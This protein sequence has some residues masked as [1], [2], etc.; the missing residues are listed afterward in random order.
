MNCC[1]KLS[2][3]ASILLF[4]ASSCSK[5]FERVQ[6]D[7]PPLASSEPSVET[8]PKIAADQIPFF[9]QQTRVGAVHTTAPLD[10]KIITKALKFPWSLAFLPDGRMLVTEKP[11]NMRI[12]TSSGTVGAPITGLPPVKYRSNSGL[13]DVV[14]DP[15]FASTRSIFWV[16]VEPLTP[17]NFITSIAKGKLSVDETKLE[18]LKIIYRAY[19]S[20]T[21]LRHNG[22]QLLFDKSGYLYACFGEHY[23][24]VVRVLAQDLSSSI[25][26]II[27][28]QKDG[29]AAPGN[30]F[31]KTPGALPEIWSLGHRDPQGL[32]FNPLTGDLWESEHGPM[33]GDEINLI[34]AGYNYGWPVI[35]YGYENSGP[36]MGTTVGNGTHQQGMKQP[37]YYWDPA[38]AP[39]GIAFY[40]GALI[41]EWK[42]N[43]FVAS[44]LGKHI[45]RLVLYNNQVFGE[46][47][48]LSGEGQRFRKVIQGPDGAIYAITDETEGRI[49]RI[50]V[51]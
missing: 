39:S 14:L 45:S 35:A 17:T 9:Q 7:P 47:R 46:E 50:G 1:F 12:V 16:F 25:G 37:V 5:K 36:L 13:L 30:P 41:P 44:L 18:D 33:A 2:L 42:N 28:I 40:T 38:I 48:L 23:D 19:P 24:D 49:Y 27:R 10:V 29:T 15:D 6:V 51:K 22:A 20:Y 34:R 43:L 26:K 4:V 3:A 21:E 32:A 31:A 8:L 11:G